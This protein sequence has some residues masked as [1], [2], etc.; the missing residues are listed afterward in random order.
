MADAAGV[1][2]ARAG[3]AVAGREVRHGPWCM[4][5]LAWTDFWSIRRSTSSKRRAPKRTLSVV[6]WTNCNV[7]KPSARAPLKRLMASVGTEAIP[8][9]RP[10]T[11]SGW[12]PVGREADNR[13]VVFSKD[14]GV[15]RPCSRHHCQP[16][17]T[18]RSPRHNVHRVRLGRGRL[19]CVRLQT[20]ALCAHSPRGRRSTSRARE[21][22]RG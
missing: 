6:W 18:S 20:R 16:R 17:D 14:N 3:I 19:R 10:C 2:D 4:I 9:C 22:V 11:V 5:W 8:F 13:L 21:H 1:H 7:S 12:A 15:E